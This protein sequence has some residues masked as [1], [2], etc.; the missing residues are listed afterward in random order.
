MEI[1]LILSKILL[2]Y[3]VVPAN[4]EYK[5]PKILKEGAFSA[6]RLE[7]LNV[8]FKKRKEITKITKK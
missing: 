4:D 6:H 3:D 8:I 2:R 1:K 5:N 7:Y